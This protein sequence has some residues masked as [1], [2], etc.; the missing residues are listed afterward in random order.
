MGSGCNSK[1]GLVKSVYIQKG[2]GSFLGPTHI[3][4]K[5]KKVKWVVKFS[6]IWNCN[7]AVGTELGFQIF[8]RL[9]P[10]N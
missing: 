8:F 5:H 3:K 4:V 9:G 7:V 10:R 2:G 1:D 6:R